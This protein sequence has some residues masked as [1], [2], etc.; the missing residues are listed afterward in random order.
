VNPN[1]SAVAAAYDAV[2]AEYDSSYTQKKSIAENRIVLGHLGKFIPLVNGLIADLGCG[3]GF[4]LDYLYVE[5]ERYVGIDISSGMIA[6][7]KA[8]H[9]DYRFEVGRMES[10]SF[11]DTGSV[12]LAVSLFG[13]FSYAEPEAAER[14]IFRIL[15]PGG[16]F[17]VMM[18]G[19]RYQD[20]GTY[21]LN[22]ANIEVAKN[23]YSAKAARHLF[24]SFE[25]V[26]VLGL[27]ALVDALPEWLP[28]SIFDQ[29]LI[30]EHMLVGTLAPNCNY[31][32][33]A[34]GRKPTEWE[35]ESL[36]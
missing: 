5:P 10:V 23:L 9:P 29:Y 22:R 28:Q 11:V 33:I 27:S 14:E 1:H 21:I 30:L 13:S 35:R 7:A 12:E 31:F 34:A 6:R 32:L 3:T 16:L 4:L 17:L 19:E 24:R 36:A 25:F 2:A 8:K 26:N 15:R 18:L 20:R